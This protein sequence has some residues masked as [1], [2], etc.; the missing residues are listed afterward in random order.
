MTID[1]VIELGEKIQEPGFPWHD[2]LAFSPVATSI[3]YVILIIMAFSISGPVGAS[4]ATMLIIHA[5]LAYS[6]YKDEIMY[7]EQTSKWETEVGVHF[8]ESLPRERHDLL[9]IEIH[10]E[11][12]YTTRDPFLWGDGYTKETGE[13]TPMTI[14]FHDEN[15]INEKDYYEVSLSLDEGKKPYIEYQELEEYLGH[16][17]YEGRYN[18]KIYL[19]K[20][21]KITAIK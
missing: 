17:F 12:D 16:G 18:E 9:Y 14:S 15:L 1:K 4:I 2:A 13:K 20:D 6:S 19:P 21:Y 3:L 11:L 8:I 7:D 10:S 5:L